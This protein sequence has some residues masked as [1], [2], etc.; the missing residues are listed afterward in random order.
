MS[1]SAETPTVPAA[2]PA[3]EEEVVGKII[4]KCH[5]KHYIVLH[6]HTITITNLHD[7]K[8]FKL[9]YNNIQNF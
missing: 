4:V 3:T 2:V 6:D 5:V 1:D 8:L 9:H 7:H